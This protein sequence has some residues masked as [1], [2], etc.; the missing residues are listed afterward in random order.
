MPTADI[1]TL[2]EK[3]HA[4]GHGNLSHPCTGVHKVRLTELS[5][6]AKLNIW[7]SL[8]RNKNKMSKC[9]HELI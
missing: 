4:D 7:S 2:R 5:D 3:G 1:N 6:Q 8:K 9:G